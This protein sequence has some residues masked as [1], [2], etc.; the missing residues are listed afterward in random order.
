[1][2][3]IVENA[4]LATAEGRMAAQE[5][6]GW[7]ELATRVLD[8]LPGDDSVDSPDNAVQ[9]AIAALQDAAPAAPAGAFVES[10]GL[11]SPAWDQAQVDL[12]DACDA[13]GA[14]LA[15][16]VFTGG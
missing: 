13:A 15:I 8:R 2:L 12:A 11:G 6:D 16:M 3:T 10:S 4:G 9:A 14:P 5:R 1:M 7:H